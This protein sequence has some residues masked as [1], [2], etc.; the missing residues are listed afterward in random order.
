MKKLVFAVFT[1]L[2]LFSG[3]SKKE[4]ARG[5]EIG[6]Q[7]E[8]IVRFGFVDNGA[9]F[10]TDE[11]AI[12]LEKGFLD[13]RLSS[14]GA[15]IDVLPFAGAGP[16]INEAFASGN[17]DMAVYG[18]V[19]NIVAKSNGLG[20]RLIA[21]R[22]YEQ[23]AGIVVRSDS[24]ISSVAQLRGKSVATQKGS[25][26]HRTL[27]EI[28]KS[29]G[30]ALDSIDFVN[31]TPRD[32]IPSLISGNIDAALLPSTSL[33]K[34]ITEGGIKLLQDCGDNPQWQGSEGLIV[35]E[36]FLESNRDIIQ[37]VLD[38]LFDAI[39]YIPD[40]TEE[41]KTILTKSGF[42]RAVFD[43]LYPDKLDFDLSLDGNA[44]AAYEEVKRFLLDNELIKNDFSIQ[45]WADSDFIS[46][47]K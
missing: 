36:V 43:Y 41:C 34:V 21:A 2:I 8:R 35:S 30:L 37:A 18:D 38:G 46:T 6:A 12:A 32:G 31:M 9:G 16:A 42:S 1:A 25:Y 3:C 22:V 23:Q 33:A 17:L 5:P 40:N 29:N 14:I 19:P 15:R 7:K 11:F 20:T 10:P 13:K 28:L 27:V 45:D 47:I 39:A 24:P 4:A 26:M 44:I